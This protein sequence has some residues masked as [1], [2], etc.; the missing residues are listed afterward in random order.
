M[1][2]AT[3]AI[4][5]R[6]EVSRSLVLGLPWKYLLATMFVAVC[7]QER[8]TSTSS[9]RKIVTPFSLPITAGRFSHSTASNGDILPSVKNLSNTNPVFTGP[10]LAGLL[11]AAFSAASSVLLFNAGF[12]VAISHSSR[13][14]G[15]PL[16]GTL[17]FYYSA[18]LKVAAMPS[19]HSPD[20]LTPLD[21]NGSPKLPSTGQRKNKASR[22]PLWEEAAQNANAL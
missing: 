18:F 7:D 17:L 4:S 11:P 6:T 1:V 10:L 21:S 8:G 5:C 22:A 20:P 13:A 16:A 3:R 2:L 9:W 14:F 15:L 12:T 19:E